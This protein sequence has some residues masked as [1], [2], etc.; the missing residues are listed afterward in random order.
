M[1]LYL[2]PGHGGS[3]PGAQGNGLKEK[4]IALDIA[5]RI[6]TIL[7][8][9]YENVE[10]KMSRTSDISKGLSERTNEANFWKADYYLSIHC[11][12]YNG[13]AKGYEDFIH[14]SLSDSSTTAKYRDILHVEIMK[15]NQLNNRRKK[16]D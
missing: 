7:I 14:S 16:K 2:D 8:N 13:S 1:K 15:A 9:N 6:R 11:N 12:A 5:L 4:Y 3:D 10:V